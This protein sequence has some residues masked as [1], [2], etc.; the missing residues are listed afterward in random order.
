MLVNEVT[1]SGAM[2]ALEAVMRFAA[3]RQAVIAGNI[4][5]ISTPDYRQQD[6]SVDGFR[7]SLREAV[8]RRREATGGQH[9]MLGLRETRELRMDA[10]GTLRAN[11]SVA[12]GTGSILYHDR[13]NRNVERLMQDQ[14][15]N[16]TTFRVAADLLRSKYDLMRSAMAERV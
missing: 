6:L 9:G 2:P 11:P 5:N 4:A 10:D 12:K 15:E 14:V 3:Q 7:A 16:A 13:G 8:G 1:S